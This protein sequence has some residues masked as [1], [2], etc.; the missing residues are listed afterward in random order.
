MQVPQFIKVPFLIL[1]FCIGTSIFSQEK[2]MIYY[3]AQWKPTTKENHSFYRPLPL[4]KLGNLVL[5]E[6]FYKNGN[7]QMQGYVLKVNQDKYIGDIHWYD[8]NGLDLNFSQYYN[9]STAPELT[10]YYP[11][12][13]LWKKI[14]YEDEIKHGNT[15][16]YNKDGTILLTG[17]YKRGQ[18]ISG[19]FSHLDI[20]NDYYGTSFLNEEIIDIKPQAVMVYENDIPEE[21]VSSKIVTQPKITI[22]EKAFWLKGNHLAQIK[23]YKQKKYEPNEIEL[24]SQKNY[25]TTNQ[26]LQD[27]SKENIQYGNTIK[28]GITYEYYTQNDFVVGLKSETP[29]I[30]QRINGKITNYHVNGKLKM[31]AN[32]K[33]GQKEG[34]ILEFNDLGIVQKKIVY[35][36]GAPFEGN[37]KIQFKSDVYIYSTYKNGLQVGNVIAKTKS[38]STITEGIYKD[39]KPFEGSFFI[40]ND[41]SDNNEIIQV[42]DF[43]KIGKQIIFDNDYRSPSETYTIH[44]GMKNG[45]YIFYDNGKVKSTINYKDDKPYEGTLSGENETLTYHSGELIEQITHNS[46][47]S[48]VQKVV[49]QLKN[50]LPVKVTY[51]QQ[52]LLTDHPQTEYVGI[53][54]NGKPFDGYFSEKKNEFKTVE[55][56]E[57]GEIKYQYSNDYL[58][59][60]EKYHFPEYDLKSTYKNGKVFDGMEYRKESKT[61][62]TKTW[63]SGVLHSIDWDVFAVHYFNRIRFAMVGNSIEITEYQ[64]KG[65]IIIEEKNNKLI[66]SILLNDKVITTNTIDYRDINASLPKSAN[67]IYMIKNETVVALDIESQ[68]MMEFGANEENGNLDILFKIYSNLMYDKNTVKDYFETI[69]NILTS[70][71]KFYSFLKFNGD[72][73]ENNIIAGLKTDDKSQGIIGIHIKQNPNNTY[74]LQLYYNSKSIHI[75]KN[76][77]FTT[78]KT[79]TKKLSE[80]LDSKINR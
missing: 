22:F 59:N 64:S 68:K 23:G 51:I 3:D 62:I 63:K 19:D 12:G 73:K 66:K 58:K 40:K 41:T 29:V 32:Y 9:T 38:D 8:V 2:S 69:A 56:Y 37:F 16:I 25:S 54:N 60:M 6:D 28:N 47:Q 39:G 55:Y 1:F 53:Y 5:I 61:F 18:P 57:K 48:K 75:V 42:A 76:I 50:N 49:L 26:L 35:K 52:F 27:L 14:Q 72:S 11:D 79:E 43:K 17:T 71:D 33:N 30:N 13:K 80:I 10:Y 31:I 65:K 15:T 36:Q 77:T 44:N 45:E 70:E 74:D 24:I 20:S 67:R 78:L 34:E 7:R 21:A 4:K 46:Y